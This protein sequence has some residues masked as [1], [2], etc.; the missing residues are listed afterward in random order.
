MAE[1]PLFDSGITID[2]IRQMHLET[3]LGLQEC[4][5]ILTLEA[6]NEAIK[7]AKTFEEAK[8]ALL[9]LIGAVL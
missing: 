6:I 7:N 9:A 8:P 3:Q 4:K 2:Q 5:R 1:T